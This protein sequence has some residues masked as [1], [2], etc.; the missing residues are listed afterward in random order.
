[1]N[2]VT[3]STRFELSTYL[4][5]VGFSGTPQP[6][7][8]TLQALSEGHLMAIPF[9]NLNAYI[10]APVPIDL[11]SVY[12][13]LVIRGRG[14]YCFEQNGLFAAV[15]RQ[16]GFRVD[17][18]GARVLDEADP[19]RITSLS[20]Q[21]LLVY[22]E[23]QRYLVDV[24]FGRTSLVAP[25]KLEPGLI[26]ATTH[27]TYRIDTYPGGEGY[28]LETLSGERWKTMYRFRLTPKYPIDFE[29]ANWYVS[30]HP[31]SHFT[32]Q[33]SVARVFPKG[34]YTL[35]DNVFSTYYL[36]G[37]VE[38]RELT[39]AQDLLTVLAG[40]FGVNLESIPE[41]GK[42]FEELNSQTG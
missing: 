30:T 10:G 7:W 28:F 37:S 39:S 9:E 29:V 34:R 27:G 25:L 26:Q 40:P 1:M 12:E 42:R 21:L 22:L 4:L 5:R 41:V 2:T 16:I 14:G 35:K 13:K 33:L 6:D 11:D 17:D 20:H 36:T 3:L 32:H 31:D 23:D 15:L 18:L 19:D 38:R 24:G 8:A